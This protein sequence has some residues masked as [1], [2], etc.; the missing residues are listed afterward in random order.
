MARSFGS[1]RVRISRALLVS[2]GVLAL[3]VYLAAQLMPELGLG[4]YKWIALGV[5][6]TA[7]ATATAGSGGSGVPPFRTV[8]FFNTTDTRVKRVRVKATPDQPDP[9]PPLSPHLADIPPGGLELNQ[10][11][12]G[13][14]FYQSVKQLTVTV[15]LEDPAR[16]PEADITF[17]FDVDAQQL[18]AT[19]NDC[20]ALL[21]IVVAGQEGEYGGSACGVYG[22]QE[23]A[24][25]T[26]STIYF[27]NQP[28]APPPPPLDG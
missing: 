6:L 10:A 12:E 22:P 13:D 17:S 5:A 1:Q 7:L 28:L 4:V 26:T 8:Q 23:P 24:D 3:L 19:T 27:G 20:M 16:R 14:S 11:P 25:Q 15:V 9:P 2:I 21:A 18:P